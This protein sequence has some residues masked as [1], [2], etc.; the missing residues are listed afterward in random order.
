MVRALERPALVLAVLACAQWLAAALLAISVDHDGWLYGGDEGGRSY[1]AA[2]AVADGDVP[3]AV[4]GYLW[5]YV[6]APFALVAGDLDTALPPIV[7]TQVLAFGA[8]VVVSIYALAARLGGQVYAAAATAVWIALPFAVMPLFDERYHDRYIEQLLPRAL[9]LVFGAEFASLV[10]V[11]AAAALLARALVAT[12]RTE[13]A[14]AGLTAGLAAAVDPWNL[15]FAPAALLALAVARRFRDV[16]PF[17]AGMAPALLTLALWRERARGSVG[18]PP[19]VTVDW[20]VLHLNYE[21]LREYLWG[22]GLIV[23]LS[24]LGFVG[25]ARRSLPLASALAAWLLAFVVFR[26]AAPDVSM[27]DGT[28][29]RELLPAFPAFFLLAAGAPLAVPGIGARIAG[30]RHDLA[31]RGRAPA[32]VGAVALALAVVPLAHVVLAD[33]RA[34]AGVDALTRLAGTSARMVP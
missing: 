12:R 11:L 5:P 10:L 19:D 4:P 24:V 8:V 25:V 34:A 6:F 29:F 15:L 28:F 27:Q 31:L 3:V 26:G 30:R 33:D 1:A 17:A 13:A 18:L 23:W 14:I 20:G 22:P 16:V 7:V 32:A 9:G 21:G 2:R